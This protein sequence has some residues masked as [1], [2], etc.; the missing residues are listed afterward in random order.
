[1]AGDSSIGLGSQRP[2][3]SVGVTRRGYRAR[4][5]AQAVQPASYKA[6][7]RRPSMSP[8]YMTRLSP[9]TYPERFEIRRANGGAFAGARAG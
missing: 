1:M 3:V 8:P 9:I 5:V 2:F 4:T 6:G 7:P